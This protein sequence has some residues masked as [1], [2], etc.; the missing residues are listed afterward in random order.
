M[1][2]TELVIKKTNNE[3][4]NYIRNNFDINFTQSLSIYPKDK[5]NIEFV[6]LDD[7]KLVE[8]KYQMNYCDCVDDKFINLLKHN[9]NL[10][11]E[12]I[13]NNIINDLGSEHKYLEAF[14]GLMLIY[15]RKFSQDEYNY[16]KY[17]KMYMKVKSEYR[18]NL[19]ALSRDCF[20]FL[21]VKDIEDRK[22]YYDCEKHF[23]IPTES[24]IYLLYSYLDSLYILSHHSS[25]RWSFIDID[26]D[27]TFES[28]LKYF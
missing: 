3:I 15:T 9:E 28:Y 22:M 27:E 16:N 10:T 2:S 6:D 4:P 1:K 17:N 23:N 7:I 12:E 5:I 26:K 14:I 24:Y 8:P 21:N 20:D 18:D 19:I 25:I 13:I 11:E